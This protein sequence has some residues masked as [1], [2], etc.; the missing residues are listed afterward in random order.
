MTA[1]RACIVIALVSEHFFVVDFGW[2]G[3]DFSSDGKTQCVVG[4][5]GDV[6]HD[7]GCHNSVGK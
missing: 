3:F 6:P 5:P 2:L 7:G 1:L 4:L